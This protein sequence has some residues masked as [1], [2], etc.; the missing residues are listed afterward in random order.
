MF[1]FCK[2]CHSIISTLKQFTIVKLP[3]LVAKKIEYSQIP[4][5]YLNRKLVCAKIILNINGLDYQKFYILIPINRVEY[6]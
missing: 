1:Y 2:I 4:F 6:A 3:N 5:L